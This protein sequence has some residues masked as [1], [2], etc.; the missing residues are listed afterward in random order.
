MTTPVRI[1]FFGDSLV[2]GTGD[3]DGL[4]WVGRLVSRERR[5]GRDV[6]AYNLGVR[7]DTS[8]DIAARWREEARRRLPR[9]C[10]ARLL[11]SFGAN[12]CIEEAGCARVPLE[13]TLA[14][15]QEILREAATL[16]P[17]LMVGPFLPDV[18]RI[19]RLCPQL[20]R[21]CAEQR[22][23]YIETHGFAAHCGV[24]LSEAAAGDGAHPNSG[25][26]A[27]LADFIG[28][29]PQWRAWLDGALTSA[30]DAPADR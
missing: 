16:A 26:Y 24:L 30:K 20:Q 11:F 3:D 27:A 5:G 15:A 12:D 9:D 29:A 10:D 21:L 23:P 1:C 7:R 4:G 18:A 2:N 14:H 8:A 25:G 17:V 13:E 28:A 22:I 19:D 6:T